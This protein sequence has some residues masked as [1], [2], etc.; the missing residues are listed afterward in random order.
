MC[1]VELEIVELF[2]D[3]YFAE[4]GVILKKQLK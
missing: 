2:E 1:S 4:L 3:G